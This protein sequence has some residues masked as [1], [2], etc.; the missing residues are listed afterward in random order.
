M[1]ALLFVSPRAGVEYREVTGWSGT[2]DGLVITLTG[3]EFTA[4]YVKITQPYTDR[5]YTFANLMMSL[6]HTLPQPRQRF[7]RLQA[8]T[9]LDLGRWYTMQVD[10][11]LDADT[12]TT[13]IDDEVVSRLPVLHPASTLTHLLVLPGST[14]VV[15]VSIDEVLAQD[16]S[17]GLPTIRRIGPPATV[18]VGSAD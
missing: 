4:R 16:M 7:S 15:D 12:V 10:F 6:I 2:K 9:T 17:R 14:G 13:R 8:P 5:A 1:T 11:D 18:P 3:P